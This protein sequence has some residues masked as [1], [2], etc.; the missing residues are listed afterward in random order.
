M[1]TVNGAETPTVRSPFWVVSALVAVPTAGLQ[2]AAKAAAEPPASVTLRSVSGMSGRLV[3]FVV[4]VASVTGPP[5]VSA[6]GAGKRIV[7]AGAVSDPVR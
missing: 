1:A 7:I 3:K 5:S 2:V 6:N 4:P